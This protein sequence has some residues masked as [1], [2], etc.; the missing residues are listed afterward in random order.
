MSEFSNPASSSKSAGAAY[1]HALLERLGQR[2]PLPVWRELADAVDSL[3]RDVS[4]TDARRPEAPGKWSMVQV[5]AHL[6]DSEIVYAYRVRL[7]VAEDRPEILGY[8]QDAFATQLGY[9]DEP[10]SDLRTELRV[11]RRR[12]LRFV[13]RLT[14]QQ[15]TRVGMHNERGPES[16]SHVINMLAAHDL[17]HR[18]QLERIRR[19]LGL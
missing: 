4:A 16:V 8:D 10:L 3:T 1:T 12:N 5:V 6:V 17:V 14:A 11:L 19:T 15:L 7:I 18:A 2:D 9:L 13:E